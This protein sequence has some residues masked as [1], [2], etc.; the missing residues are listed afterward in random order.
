M[1]EMD[2]LEVEEEEEEEREEEVVEEREE[3]REGSSDWRR[4]STMLRSSLYLEYRC[5]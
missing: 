5:D 3:E 4:L 1:D 2:E